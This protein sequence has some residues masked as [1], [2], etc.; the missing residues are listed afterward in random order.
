MSFCFAWRASRACA[1]V[2]PFFDLVVVAGVI[3]VGIV[4][5]LEG[6]VVDEEGDVVVEGVEEDVVVEGFVDMV[7]VKVEEDI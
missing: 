7:S 4:L 5:V 6:F 2:E 1:D 3:V